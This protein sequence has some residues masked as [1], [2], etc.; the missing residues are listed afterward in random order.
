MRAQVAS[1]LRR[2]SEITQTY[3]VINWLFFQPVKDSYFNIEWWGKY[4]R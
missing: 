3:K 4:K 1:T 2:Q